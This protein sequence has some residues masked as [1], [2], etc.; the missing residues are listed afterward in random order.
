MAQDE[1]TNLSVVE[2][3]QALGNGDL[4][5]PEYVD[6]LLARSEKFSS[7]NAFVTLEGEKLREKSR[8]MNRMKSPL[9]GLPLIIKDNIDVAGMPTTACTPALENWFPRSNAAITQKLIDA[10]AQVMGKGSMHELAYGITSDNA[11]YG[12]VCNPY[13]PDCIPGGSSSG[14]AAAIASR[15][16]PAGLGSD[17][18]GSCRMPA[19]L[20]GCVGFRPSTG[21]Y[22]SQGVM[23]LSW[24]RDTAGVLARTVDDI[25]LLDQ[26][27]SQD[28]VTS[29]EILDLKGIRLGIPRTGFYDDLDPRTEQV[30]ESALRQLTEAGAVLIEAEIKNVFELEMA[31][32]FPAVLFEAVR[33]LSVYLG[34]NVSTI[35][36]SDIIEKISDPAIKAMLSEQYS[37]NAVTADIYFAGVVENRPKLQQAYNDYFRE[38]KVDAIVVPTTPLPA[39]SRKL[40][41]VN[42]SIE[43]NGRQVDTFLTYIRNV[44]ASSN[45]GLPALSIPAG[46]TDVGLP[47]GIEF[48]GSRLQ[49]SKL[50]SIGRAFEYCK[51]FFPAPS[52]NTGQGS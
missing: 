46:L 18:G 34:R 15:I 38:H 41:D 3:V 24:T 40:S 1:I 26:I 4:D 5:L 7:L 47:V 6:A 39:R 19:S 35:T 36:V 44:S 49:D 48:V 52:L 30:M 42:K 23:C 12:N 27:C 9:H 29:T 22:S 13:D 28:E 50:L 32:S 25:I 45:V 43:L 20:C 37:E 33:E 2:A 17:T 21:R 51:P 10:G 8:Q 14:T 16:A 11:H 31:S